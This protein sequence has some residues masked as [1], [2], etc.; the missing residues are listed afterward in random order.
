MTNRGP[1][2]LNEDLILGLPDEG[3][4]V[5]VNLVRFKDRSSDGVGSGWDAYTRYSKAISPLMREVGAKILWSGQIEGV[6]YGDRNGRYW[7]FVVLVRY[8]SRKAFLNMV[9]SPAYAEGNVHRENGVADHVIL[10]AG[11]SFSRF[12][13][14]ST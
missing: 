10:A 9:T 3:P 1:Q 7:D 13:P 4:V 8:P 6:A 11:E 2:E 12:V 5:M 14:T